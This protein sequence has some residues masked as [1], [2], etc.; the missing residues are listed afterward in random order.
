M[1]RGNGSA[2]AETIVKAAAR[3]NTRRITMRRGPLRDTLDDDVSTI[4]IPPLVTCIALAWGRAFSF[5]SGCAAEQA[6]LS[7][8]SLLAGISEIARCF[9]PLALP[10]GPRDAPSAFSPFATHHTGGFRQA[11]AASPHISRRR[12]RWQLRSSETPLPP[13]I[14]L[15]VPRSAASSRRM[16]GAPLDARDDRPKHRACQVAFG[17]L[18]REV[19]GMP[20][21][22][23][24]DLEQPPLKTG[25][26]PAL[27]GDGQDEPT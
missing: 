1:V 10:K 23:S 18:Q 20:N 2:L 5:G 24:A 8:A 15:P 21:E 3:P 27:K 7:E 12:C 25:E 14:H 16:P 19:P 9:V 22:A 26:G 11:N 6:I 13:M 17:E 4:T